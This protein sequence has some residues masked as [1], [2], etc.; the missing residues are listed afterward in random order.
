MARSSGTAAIRF[1]HTADW[2]LG[3]TRHFLDEDAQPR[4][5]AARIEAIAAMGRVIAER[6]C[7]FVVVCGDV[8]ESNL[9]GARLVR[10][11]LEAMA[12]LAVPVYLL[13]GNH[14]PFDAASVYRS[15]VFAEHRPA[16]VT[17]L[18]RAETVTVRAGVELV[19]AP[20]FGKVPRQDLVAQAV[21]QL[22]PDPATTRI[23]VGHG[24]A[25]VLSA[26]PA[27]RAVIG[28]PGLVEALDAGLLDYVA[29]GDR[30]S[31]TRVA[32]R[33]IWYSGTPEATDYDEVDPG[34]VLVVAIDPD[35]RVEVESVPIGTWRF[36]DLN[37]RLGGDDDL[38][39]F[40]VELE[41]RRGK[42]RTALRLSLTGTLSLAQQLRLDEL[43]DRQREVYAAIEVWGKRSELSVVVD[44]RELTDLGVGGFAADAVAEL[45]ELT[46]TGGEDAAA[47]RDALSLMYRLTRRG[48]A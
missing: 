41:R 12:E 11:A 1:L 8:F 7:E 13:P 43:L 4:Y 27:N 16:N 19:A 2:Q 30:H 47:A 26:D 15:P 38:A 5:T 23:L 45:V 28:T 31:T 9:L 42:D 6:G 20:W 39:A 29:L 40:E 10:R 24:C 14:D 32:D 37:R 21:A 17:V 44:P 18:E 33:A 22:A 3:M 48:A 25:D 34:N 46:A 36:A 35:R